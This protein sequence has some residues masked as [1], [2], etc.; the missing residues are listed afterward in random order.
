[1]RQPQQKTSLL[2]TN[3]DT[4][5]DLVRTDKS[6]EG[7]NLS[8]IT[9]ALRLPFDRRLTET[10]ASIENFG[11]LSIP[12]LINHGIRGAICDIDATLVEHHGNDFSPLVLEKLG[13]LAENLPVVFFSN[14]NDQRS[15]LSQLDIPYVTNVKPKPH[16]Q[17]FLKALDMLKVTDPKQAVMIGDS[18]LTDAGCRYA[19]IPFIHVQPIPGPE[20]FFHRLSRSYGAKIA[21]W[22]HG[23]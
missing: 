9:H 11:D 1:M 4:N 5:T 22:Y 3:S 12:Y 14:N 18:F 19:E 10:F 17:G 20:K 13:E 23:K 2:A 21:K 16:P 7:L 8:K 6:R 15:G